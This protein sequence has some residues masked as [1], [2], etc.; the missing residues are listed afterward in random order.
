MFL[1][2]K[3]TQAGQQLH[4]YLYLV[5]SRREGDRVRQHVVASLGR[6]D[7]LLRLEA[8]Q[9]LFTQLA[10]H[11]PELR[12]RLLHEG[13][14][15]L[16]RQLME[17]CPELRA[18]WQRY[19]APPLQVCKERA[20][21]PTL[22][23][24]PLWQASGLKAALL[25]LPGARGS[26][27]LERAAFALVQHR[28]FGAGDGRTDEEWV[29]NTQAEGFDGL[30]PEALARGLEQLAQHWPAI[31]EKLGLGG[32]SVS[33]CQA[34]LL[35]AARMA[36]ELTA[37][38]AAEG[39]PDTPLGCALSVPFGVR[40]V[41]SPDGT[42]LDFQA[43]LREERGGASNPPPFAAL[44][45]PLTA[46]RWVAV[47]EG[48][49][50]GQEG[51]PEAGRAAD[52]GTAARRK[53]IDAC[54]QPGEHDEGKSGPLDVYEIREGDVRYVL[55]HDGDL[56]LRQREE[57]GRVLEEI[58]ALLAAGTMRRRAG[59]GRYRPYL[60]VTQRHVR[61][62]EDR[63]REEARYDGWC[64]VC[65]GGELPAAGV[66]LAYWHY[67]WLEQLWQGF[68]SLPV[69]VPVPVPGGAT[70]EAVARDRILGHLFAGFLAARLG[71]E[72]KARLAP[73]AGGASWTEVVRRLVGLRC[74]EVGLDEARCLMRNSLDELT[75]IYLDTLRASIPPAA[76]LED[77]FLI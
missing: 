17:A 7:E 51:T 6:L 33:R 18:T 25:G 57:R 72:L 37:Q 19:L 11:A 26:P 4:H 23:L 69:P 1:R 58:R 22:A 44:S 39:Y 68:R 3:T 29:Q 34:E 63:V 52:V 2:V 70:V 24:E 61:I 8:L 45:Q 64:V 41:V 47:S 66:A 21:G 74:V 5:Q 65:A 10:A 28:L 77:Y 53:L 43:W 38:P 54:R 50:S 15:P 71:A 48:V 76:L 27:P 49:V 59:E 20:W 56:A 46:R 13:L 40:V 14:E 32:S 31:E 67:L 73:V 42:P 30:R 35:I 36:T 55:L 12:R 62:D 60:K 75:R 9:R 16:V